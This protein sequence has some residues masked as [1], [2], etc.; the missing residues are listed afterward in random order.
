MMKSEEIRKLF[1][2]YFK[3]RGHKILPSSSLIPIDD[4][5]VLLTTA[6][7]QQF[8]KYYTREKD[9]IKDFGTQRTATIQK[10][11][12]TTDIEEIGDETHLTFFEMLGNFSFGPVGKDDP[13]NFGSD[14]Y[15][16]RAAIYWAY[17]F[18]KNL[19][20]EIDYVTV[21]GGER[22]VPFDE[23]SYKI[24]KEVGFSEEK[25]LKKGREDNFWGPTGDE[26]PCGPTTEIY[27]NNVEIWNLVFNEYYQDKNGNLKKLEFPGV[28]TGM[29]FERLMKVSQNVPTIFETDFFQPLK[30]VLDQLTNKDD[31]RRKR[32]V[33]DHIRGSVFLIADGLYPSNLERG[34][35]LRRILR[36]LTLNLKFLDIKIEKIENMI[37]AVIEKYSPFYPELKN[38]DKIK[39]VIFEE[40][41][42]FERTLNIGLREFEKTIKGNENDE[43]L[44]EKLFLLYTSYGLPLE[45]SKELLKDN[46]LGWTE[47][48]Q[49]VFD[50]LFKKHQEISK[51]RISELAS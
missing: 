35:V 11:F 47:K 9:P 14:G 6:G 23:E 33:L 40:I 42:N 34:Y 15:F 8:K 20:L 12:R 32:I 5:S 10:C 21:F 16:K 37:K 36:R 19:D 17:E 45:I 46:G 38:Y 22:D 7:M 49:Q 4:H 39:T 2:D 30:E 26:G 24:W 27:V 29:G 13:Q 44:A 3:A 1:L 31:I 48:S 50:E 51:G 43:I 18:I 28:D 25:I 41:I